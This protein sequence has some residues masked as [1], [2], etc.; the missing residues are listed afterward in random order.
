MDWDNS[1]YTYSDNNISHIWNVL[2]LVHEKGWLVV[3]HRAMPWCAR[4]GTALSRARDDGLVQGDDAH[5]SRAS[6]AFLPIDGPATGER[7][8]SRGRRRRGRCR[9]TW[10]SRSIRT[11]TTRACRVRADGTYGAGDADPLRGGLQADEVAR[12]RAARDVQGQDAAGTPLLGTVRR[13]ADRRADG[14]GHRV[15]AWDEVGGGRGHRHRAH[16]AGLRR[17]GLRAGRREGCR[18]RAHRRGRR[19][20]TRASAGS[21]ERG[22]RRRDRDRR[23]PA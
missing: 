2:K 7:P 23:R 17:G 20:S 15:I 12:R 4:C 8:S 14:T 9:R 11:L 1:Y 3:G 19:M 22:A 18:R 21:R 6:S 5:L 13:A 10:H 16:R